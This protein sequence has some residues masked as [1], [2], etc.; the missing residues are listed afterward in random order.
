M[1]RD[2]LCHATLDAVEGLSTTEVKAVAAKSGTRLNL[3]RR[4]FNRLHA[5][6][7]CALQHGLVGVG[8]ISF[9]QH[10]TATFLRRVNR[11]LTTPK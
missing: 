7:H 8:V 2:D 5:A 6:E 9:G 4:A 10:R 11:T 1:T 3:I